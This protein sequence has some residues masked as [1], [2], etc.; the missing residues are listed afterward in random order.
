MQ[1]K[2]PFEEIDH[3]DGGTGLVVGREV[4][5]F[6]VGTESL[7]GMTGSHTTC[8]VVFARHDIL[9]DGVDG[10]DIVGVSRQGCHIGHAGIHITGTYGMAPGFRLFHDWLVA[11][12]ID[13]LMFCLATVV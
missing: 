5:Q 6:I 10:L 1:Q 11:L 7:S 13:V 12:R 2:H 3:R 9:V 8:Q 4:G